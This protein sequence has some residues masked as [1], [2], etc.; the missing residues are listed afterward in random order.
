MLT[1]PLSGLPGT[2]YLVQD[3]TFV[4]SGPKAAFQLSKS[5]ELVQRRWKRITK[6]DIVKMMQ[7]RSAVKLP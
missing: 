5:R 6:A 4:S 1:Q 7:A 2:L 3:A